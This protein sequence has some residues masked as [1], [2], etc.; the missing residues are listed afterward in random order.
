MIDPQVIATAQDADLGY[1]LAM[2]LWTVLA[3]AGTWAH[4][5][6][7]QHGDEPRKDRWL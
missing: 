3:V 6:R 7:L 2:I 1:I 4:V 5:Q